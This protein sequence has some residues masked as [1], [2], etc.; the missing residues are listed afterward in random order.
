MSKGSEKFAFT[1]YPEVPRTCAFCGRKLRVADV[2]RVD[3]V[4]VGGKRATS[5]Y[6]TE[7]M[8]EGYAL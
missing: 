6:C 8:H 3:T 4:N 2:A 7:H 5:F 1:Q